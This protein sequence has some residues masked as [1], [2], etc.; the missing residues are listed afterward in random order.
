[1]L[2]GA[3]QSPLW[4]QGFGADPFR[5]YNS[6]YDAYTYPM[7]PATPGG[8]QGAMLPRMGNA[9]AN[10]FQ[11]YL[12]EMAGAGRAET[13]RY[14]IGMPYYRS[15]IDPSFD[16]KGTRDYRPNRQA[17]QSFERSQELITRKYLAYFSEKDPKKRAGLLEEYNRTRARVSRAMSSRRENPSRTLEA[18]IGGDTDRRRPA[19]ADRAAA[20][21]A[22]AD[23]AADDSPS[24]PSVRPRSSPR[25][26]SR[27]PSAEASRRGGTGSVPPPPPL[28]GGDS[29][30]RPSRRRSPTD[31]LDR[32]RRLNPA[33]NVKPSPDARGN[34]D[35]GT[36]RQ[37]LPPALPPE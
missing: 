26:S 28:F 25:A 4:A 7:G 9:G 11:G 35:A 24:A 30:R 20:D 16:P 13:E 33:D 10:R 12:D 14:G 29:L 21:R 17:D 1:M 31:V 37:P 34:A 18:A 5:P 22:A 8:G 2:W 3:D 23:R 32:S 6:Q 27:A 15:S 36:A 19:S